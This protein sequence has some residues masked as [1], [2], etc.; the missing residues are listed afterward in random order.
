[1]DGTD[2]SRLAAFKALTPSSSTPYIIGFE[3]PDC[4]SG[5]GSADMDYTTAANLW[6]EL[7]VP[8]G[9]AGSLLLSPSMCH[10]AAETGWLQP[11]QG[12]ISRDWDITK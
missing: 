8:H 9:E 11:F 4:T 1:M 3:E 7:V 2:S 6:N 5:S 12:L 10:Q